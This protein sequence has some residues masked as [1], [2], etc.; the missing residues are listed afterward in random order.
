MKLKIPSRQVIRSVPT[1]WNSVAE[2]VKRA[3]ELR[4]ALDKLVELDRHNTV[5]KTRLRRF[6]LKT[7]EW[8][9]LVQLQP[10][11]VVRDIW[12]DILLRHLV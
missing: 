4:K 2:M 1:R 12:F 7:D 6:K 10:L 9:L 11:L 8:D 5:A 3:L